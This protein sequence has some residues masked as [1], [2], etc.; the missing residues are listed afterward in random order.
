[1]KEVLELTGSIEVVGSAAS[2][3]DAIQIL[4]DTNPDVIITDL[5]MPGMQGDV[6]VKIFHRQTPVIVITS[7]DVDDTAVIQVRG[8]ASAVILKPK[9]DAEVEK[10][11]RNLAGAVKGAVAEYL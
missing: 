7:A 9:V 5:L 3:E 6:I 10:F 11:C 1:L 4:A 2:A 8:M